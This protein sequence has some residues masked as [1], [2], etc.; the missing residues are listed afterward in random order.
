MMIGRFIHHS[1][2]VCLPCLLNTVDDA[3]RI[4]TKKTTTSF[5]SLCIQSSVMKG[6]FGP[7]FSSHYSTT[8]NF[9]PKPP[10]S[11]THTYHAIAL[12]TNT[13]TF[14]FVISL[15]K[16]SLLFRNTQ[17]TRGSPEDLNHH[18]HHLPKLCR[19]C[20]H[21][22]R[23]CRCKLETV[24]NTKAASCNLNYFHY[25]TTYSS[26]SLISFDLVSKNAFSRRVPLFLDQITL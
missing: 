19:F 8:A 26:A 20:V 13:K 14:S 9:L 5:I 25:Q 11:H 22:G 12:H 1:L 3:T 24:Y 16:S 18:H 2:F 15:F 23:I 6:V 21:D 4:C 10:P 17:P 7:S